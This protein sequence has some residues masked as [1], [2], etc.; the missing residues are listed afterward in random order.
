[1]S[2]TSRGVLL[3]FFGWSS[4]SIESTNLQVCYLPTKSEVC[5]VI[6]ILINLWTFPLVSRPEFGIGKEST[7]AMLEF[8]F[9]NRLFLL[10][11][12]KIGSVGFFLSFVPISSDISKKSQKLKASKYVHPAS[13]RSRKASC[14]LAIQ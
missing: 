7:E 9:L 4:S 6:V 1:M 13:I 5:H 10:P 2:E 14:R 3:E 8:F 12:G 11:Q